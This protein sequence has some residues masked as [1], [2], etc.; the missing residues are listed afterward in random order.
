MN[1]SVFGLLVLASLSLGWTLQSPAPTATQPSA[2][3][4]MNVLFIPVDDLNH[5]V[6]HLGRNNQVKTPNFDRLARMGVTF[7]QAHCA[8]PLCCPSRAAVLSGLRPGTTGV[9]D[10]TNDWR[11][12]IPDSITLPTFFRRQGYRVVGGGK[13]YHGGFNRDSEF[14]EM[15]RSKKEKSN[16]EVTTENGFNKIQWAQMEEGDEAMGDHEVVSWAIRQLQKKQDKPLFLACGIY[17]PHLPWNVPKKYF[18]LY[19]LDSIQLPPY[20]EDD[21]DDLPAEGKKMAAAMGDHIAMQ[22]K[23]GEKIWKEA[24]RAYMANISFA[25]AQLGRL[26]DALEK[27]RYK[28]NTAIVLWSDHGWHLGEKHHW[29]KFSL[30]E[31]ATRAPM[32]WVVPGLTKGGGVCNRPV[33]FMTI[34]PTLA[35]VAGFNVPSHCEGKSIRT[36]LAD[37]TAAWNQPAITTFG[38]NNHSV[39]TEQWRYIQYKKGGKELYDHQKDPYEWTN[40]ANDPAT[41]SVQNTLAQA[42]PKLNLP[43]IARSKGG[44]D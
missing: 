31:E 36:L 16:R 24:I 21:L 8:A 12:V 14:D 43:E 44:G 27:S 5:W 18:D 34:Y 33:D 26:L 20:R 7:T 6:R 13:V 29:R 35:D 2:A 28:A 3:Q 42:L 19:P 23:G 25:D 9:Y 32:I 15:F 30:W 22:Q 38:Q 39:R 40:V 17:R 11:T 37:P 41:K 10:N 1:E 4:P